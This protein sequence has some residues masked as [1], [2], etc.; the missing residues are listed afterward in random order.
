MTQLLPRHFSENPISLSPPFRGQ[1]LQCVPLHISS[2][3]VP[4]SLDGG[5]GGILGATRLVTFVGVGIGHFDGG[6]AV[7]ILAA[8]L[9]QSFAL[10]LGDQ[11]GGENSAEHKQSEDLHDVVQP[12][13]VG[14]VLFSTAVDQ[15]TKHALRNDGTDL[16]GG[17][18]DTVRRGTVASREALARDDEGSSVGSEVE[19]ELCE[20][21]HCQQTVIRV[22]EGLKGKPD[23]DEQDCQKD[24]AGQLDW[25]APDGID[26][27]YSDPVPRDGTSA[28]QDQVSN[29]VAV[30]RFVDILPSC[31]ADSTEDN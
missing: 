11:Q 1:A 2:V 18:A 17:G 21:V 4:V 14:A 5:H 3:A 26:C 6:I 12:R 10:G 30:E 7:V 13:R 29:G 16:A 19:E 25:L 28:D 22:L 8:E 23:D 27:G 20:D 31:P 15:G 9:L 24:K